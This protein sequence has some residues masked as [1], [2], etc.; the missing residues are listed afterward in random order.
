MRT[1]GVE[2]FALIGFAKTAPDSAVIPA[3]TVTAKCVAAGNFAV[4]F[5][6]RVSIHR[7]VPATGGV[8][9]AIGFTSVPTCATGTIGSAKRTTISVGSATSPVGANA[10]ASSGAIGFAFAGSGAG[11]ASGICFPA[12]TSAIGVIAPPRAGIA[13]GGRI[14]GA[15]AALAGSGSKRASNAAVSVSGSTVV[16][17]GAIAPP[18]DNAIVTAP[19][20]SAR[21]SSS[22]VARA[23]V[24]IAAVVGIGSIHA[25][26]FDAGFDGE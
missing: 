23:V 18:A 21:A 25:G 5:A 3:G 13:D 9:V 26:D 12:G 16:V 10:G 20:S 6:T 4:S 17:A 15:G 7:H 22:V 8:T 1:A 14:A 19:F 24:G 11:G 2:N